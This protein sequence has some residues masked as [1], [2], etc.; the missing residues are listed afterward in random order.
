MRRGMTDGRAADQPDHR[1]MTAQPP[2]SD[3]TL[4]RRVMVD[5]QL[6]V[7]KV[8]DPRVLDAMGMLPRESFVPA[9]VAD[10]AYIDADLA[11]APGRFLL[12]PLVLARLI[13]LAAARQ[14]ETA[15]VV[16]AGSGY[17]AAVLAACGVQVIALEDDGALLALARAALATQSLAALAG[18]ITLQQGPLAEGFAAHAPYDLVLIEGAVRAIPERLAR[19]VAANGRLVTVLAP[20][21]GGST[22]AIAEPSAGGLAVRPAFDA[23][24]PL[25]PSL[26]PATAFAF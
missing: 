4:A 16:G 3:F 14:G 5:G 19:Q 7:T 25:L 6:R 24:A 20:A 26:L 10:L 2:R 15:L 23:T 9:G 12:K 11:I 1:T 22:A 8:T 21:D 18:N 13:Q 17:G